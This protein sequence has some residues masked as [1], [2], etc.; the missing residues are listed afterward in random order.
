MR[1]EQL[2]CSDLCTEKMEEINQIHE[3]AKKI[4]DIGQKRPQT[5]LPLT[6]I[7]LLALGATFVGY[8][9]YECI[10]QSYC[11]AIDI[12]I[13]ILGVLFALGGLMHW[14]RAK[15]TGINW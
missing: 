8:A 9:L 4:Y 13:A 6:A 12:W 1:K 2:T 11:L 5:I 10:V 14:R 7:L 15:R 3:C